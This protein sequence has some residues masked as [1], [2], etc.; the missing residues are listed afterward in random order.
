VW[1]R[2]RWT[3]SC[4]R[5]GMNMPVNNPRFLNPAQVQTERLIQQQQAIAQRQEIRSM[6]R[7]QFEQ[8]VVGMPAKGGGHR[9]VQGQ[10]V[11]RSLNERV[12][13]QSAGG[14][15]QASEKSL[16]LSRGLTS[17]EDDDDAFPYR[18]AAR[19]TFDSMLR[20]DSQKTREAVIAALAKIHEP[21]QQY[22]VLFGA[23]KEVER[24]TDLSDDKKRSLKNAFN[25]M[26]TN[27]V[28]RDRSGIRKGLAEGAESSP[29][30]ARIEAAAANRGVSRGLRDI[31]FKIGATA[32]GGVDEQLTAMVMLKA[33]LKNVGAYYL[34]EALD[35]VCSR[36]MP[37]LRS[38]SAI[39]E[40]AYFLTVSDA[41]AFSLARS[42]LKI[43]RDFKRDLMEKSG[44]LCKS[45]HAEIAVLFFTAAEQGWG[46][47]KAIH[48]VN[49]LIDLK[50]VAALTRAQ[51]FT[52]VRNAADMLPLMAWPAD[53]QSTRIDLLED[54]DRQVFSAY[55]DIPPLTTMAERKEE[56]WRNLYAAGRAPTWVE[57]N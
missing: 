56:E 6:P 9:K 19:D 20:D 30:A 48:L 15:R 39:K 51:A 18:V 4:H 1:S 8:Q 44:L 54:L 29:V 27:L 40:T 36:L 53:K 43:A 5:I 45:H 12:T 34:E 33:L 52:A 26:M 21:L 24:Q 42:G 17:L 32:K 10:P 50:A 41:I 22:T 46:K 31:R 55:A 3:P 35:S 37:G 49:Q 11:G 25:E 23:M 13:R 47:G 7:A 28:N 16:S 57:S 38:F 14:R 2:N